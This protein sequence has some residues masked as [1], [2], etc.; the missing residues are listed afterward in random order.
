LPAAAL[1]LGTLV[2]LGWLFFYL[3]FLCVR[4][5]L[6]LSRLA[7]FSLSIN[8]LDPYALL[9]FGRLAVLY[10]ATLVGIIMLL[11]LPLGL[12]EEFVD[13]ISVVLA[14]LGTL[15]ALI[16]P[17][18]GVHRQIQKAKQD[19]LERIHD[20]FRE[21]QGILLDGSRFDK[22]ELDDLSGR[23]EKLVKLRALVWEA[24]NWPFRSSAGALRA[25]LTAL[26]PL[27]LVVLQEIVK[28]YTLFWM[29]G[30]PI[31]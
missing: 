28:S 30:P 9:P 27:L 20:Q 3:V 6:G 15:W 24:P 16:G 25:V 10:S 26:T 13:Y 7:R 12:P 5:S 1:V 18:W 23:A 8:V 29:Q 11:I 21:I 22:E 2:L 17:L 14:S 31:P 19:V 4:Y